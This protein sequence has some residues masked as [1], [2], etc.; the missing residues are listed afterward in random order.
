MILG[1]ADGTPF[2]FSS[3]A[4]SSSGMS[5]SLFSYAPENGMMA[6][7]PCSLTHSAIFASHLRDER[8]DKGENRVRFEIRV[9]SVHLVLLPDVVSL[10]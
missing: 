10:Q 2:S 5:T 6:S 3:L 7:P 4:F 1:I 8:V 9:R